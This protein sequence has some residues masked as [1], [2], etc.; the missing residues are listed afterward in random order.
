MA[1]SCK[2]SH[3]GIKPVSGGRPPSERSSRGV[4]A[5][6]AGVFAH[7]VARVL[8]LVVLFNLKIRNVENVM[9]M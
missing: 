1:S 5:V 4:R 8:I 9:I 7:D 6:R 3:L 2:I